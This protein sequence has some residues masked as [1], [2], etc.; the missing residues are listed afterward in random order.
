MKKRKIGIISLAYN[1]L[2]I[3]P[4][5]REEGKKNLEEIGIEPVFLKNAVSAMKFVLMQPREYAL[6]LKKE[7]KAI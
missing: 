1:L 7:H 6:T 5:R 3:F 4:K 2:P